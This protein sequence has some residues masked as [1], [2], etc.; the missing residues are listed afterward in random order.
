MHAP[1]LADGCWAM[2]KSSTEE[3]TDDGVVAACTAAPARSLSMLY[4]E[5]R[6]G[7]CAATEAAAGIVEDGDCC[8]G[9]VLQ[10]ST[11]AGADDN[12]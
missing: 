5:K 12:G 6:V 3:A 7:L 4:S 9:G 10:P 11:G 1:I 8:T 2:L